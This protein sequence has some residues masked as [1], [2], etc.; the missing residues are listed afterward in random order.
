[1]IENT[2][3]YKTLIPKRLHK[4]AQQLIAYLTDYPFQKPSECRHCG[5]ENI[6]LTGHFARDDKRLPQ[7]FCLS[8]ERY[9]CQ[10]TNTI[11]FNS[12][13]L[14]QWGAFGELYL[15]GYGI[16][17]I[18][19]ILKRSIH[20]IRYRID[21]TN[22]VM[23]EH[24]PELFTWWRE[25]QQRKDLRLTEAV[26]QQAQSFFA[27][28]D[29]LLYSTDYQCKYC[30][31]PLFKDTTK[32]H[33]PYFVCHPCKKYFNPL[34]GTHFK[35]SLF[36]ELWPVFAEHLINGMSTPEMEKILP[37]SPNALRCWRKLF[38]AQMQ[39]LGL[40]DLVYW[41]EWSVECTHNHQKVVNHYMHK[42]E[43]V[44]KLNGQKRQKRLKG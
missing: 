19:K 21:S 1:M 9:F 32:P 41:I 12:W 20:A 17:E 42:R 37:L 39:D 26:Q 31:R 34:N 29:H 38:I 44:I 8:C 11:F 18:A 14:D 43:Q 15:A 3:G 7:F 13:Y 35:R 23:E 27:W 36:P 10:T 24:Y 6:E 22:Q 33:R 28:L 4:Q 2:E 30:G 25:H 40:N 5:S 16:G